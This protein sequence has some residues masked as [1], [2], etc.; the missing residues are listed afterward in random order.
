MGNGFIPKSIQI[1]YFSGTGGAKRAAGA[2]MQKFGTKGIPVR[3]F[4]IDRSSAYLKKNAQAPSFDPDSLTLLLYAVHAFDAPSPIYGWIEG[5]D[6]P[7]DT[8]FAVVSVSGGGEVWPNTGCRSLV[9]KALEK[10]GC[11]VTYDAMLVMP[12]NMN[13]SSNDDAAM[14]VLN[15]MP[16]KV[17]KIIDEL[18]A[19]RNLRTGYKL[20][21]FRAF[22]TKQE[23][24]TAYKFADSVQVNPTCTGCGWCAENC[25]QNNI[26]MEN[27]RPLLGKECVVCFRCIYGCPA[28]ALASKNALVIQQGYSIHD[29]EKRMQGKVLKPIR[30]C[31]RGVLWKGV[32]KYLAEAFPDAQ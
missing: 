10:K 24:K 26:R 30:E 6:F 13:P 11:R 2:F 20:D 32:R 31:C 14:W 8:N 29:V 28:H 9:I 22:A 12:S 1:V 18:L 23:K 5:T 15:A 7:A 17:Q 25:P 16:V 27:G 19:G 3:N 21:P 4:A